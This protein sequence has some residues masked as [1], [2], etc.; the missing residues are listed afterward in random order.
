MPGAAEHESKPVNPARRGGAVLLAIGALAAVALAAM[1]AIAIAKSFTLSVEKSVKVGSKREAV[2]TSKGE[3]VYWLGGE[4]KSHLECTGGCLN[5][6]IPVKASSSHA[7]LTEAAGVSGKLG[8]VHRGN[9]FQVTLGGHLLYTYKFDPRSGAAT[10]NGIRFGPGEVWHVVSASAGSQ[11]TSKDD[12]DD[13]QHHDVDDDHD[14]F[15][16]VLPARLL[17][18]IPVPAETVSPPGR[19]GS[20]SLPPPS[21]PRYTS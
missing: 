1:S 16:D 5:I 7:R 18:G 21:P 8:T 15:I 11:S 4:T 9:S 2:A 14:Q 6:W 3:P 17:T 20:R 13:D 10:G 12:D 19:A